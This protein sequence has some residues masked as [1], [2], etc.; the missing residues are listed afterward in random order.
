VTQ[1]WQQVVSGLASGGIYGSLALA[2]VLIYRATGVI[3]FAQG[4]MATFTTFV[5]WWLVAE[6][7]LPY[8]GAV[9]LT[10]A[11]AF[12]LGAGVQLA[13]VRPF[14][15]RAEPQLTASI[16]TIG[17]FIG[18]NALTGWIWGAEQKTLRSP[19]P[20]RT[21]DIGGVA[22]SIADLGVIGVS[23]GTVVLLTL[24]FR[25]TKVG[26]GMRA[27]AIAPE[28]SRLH[29]V[30]VGRMLALGWALAAVLGAIAGLE[31][32]SPSFDP[33]LMITVLIYA[34][35]AAVLGGLDSP[36]GAVVG[37][38]AIGVFLNLLGTYVHFVSAELRLPVALLV[39]F[40][41]LLLRPAGLFGRV[42]VRRV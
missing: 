14:G 23:I 21:I 18:F 26:L 10:L 9:P 15:R 36:F 27:A 19:F 32:A 8:W 3:N 16:V 25:L 11:A 33:N 31:T 12:V 29:G 35:A 5:C 22:F 42:A 34:F 20:T 1:F 41:V 7:G 13:V 28:T 2:I 38:L 17:L 30:R 6:H 40:G 39:L 37:G 24:F 4:E